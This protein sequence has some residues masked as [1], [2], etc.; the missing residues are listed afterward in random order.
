MNFVTPPIDR[1]FQKTLPFNF[2]I[3]AKTNDW[4]DVFDA[5][6]DADTIYVGTNDNNEE[7]PFL[8]HGQAEQFNAKGKTVQTVKRPLDKAAQAAAEKAAKEAEAAEKAAKEAEAA[9]KK[10]A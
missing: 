4:A 1:F 5:H 6:P 2:N 3:M 7:Q 9:A 10:A 8:T